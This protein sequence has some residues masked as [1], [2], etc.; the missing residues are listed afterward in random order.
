MT[1]TASG[2]GT[3]RTANLEQAEWDEDDVMLF[4]L[5]NS[6]AA[7]DRHEKKRLEL[8]QRM[9]HWREGVR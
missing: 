5:G 7:K 1:G 8:T 6:K 2:S 4:F 3:R 9:K